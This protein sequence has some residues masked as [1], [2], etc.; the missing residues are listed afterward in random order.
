MELGG[1]S[2][3]VFDPPPPYNLQVRN[4]LYNYILI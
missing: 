1:D 2:A 3:K 4:Q